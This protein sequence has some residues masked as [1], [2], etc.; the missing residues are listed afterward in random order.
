M[1]TEDIRQLIY[2]ATSRNNDIAR[3]AIHKLKTKDLLEGADGVL[4]G[5]DFGAQINNVGTEYD[6]ER[7]NF[8]ADLRNLDLRRVNLENARMWSVNFSFS[9]MRGSNL[10]GAQLNSSN[11]DGVIFDDA[12]FT[13]S[14][15]TMCHSR[16]RQQVQGSISPRNAS[17]EN[18]VFNN[19]NLTSCGLGGA[20]LKGANFIKANLKHT[21]FANSD[22][23]SSVF[24]HVTLGMTNFKGSNLTYAKFDSVSWRSRTYDGE[25][26]YTI[27]P[28]GTKW[29]ESTD[30]ARFTDPDH[31]QYWNP[32]PPHPVS[33]IDWL[34]HE[35]R[36]TVGDGWL[37]DANLSHAN[38][39][40]ANLKHANLRGADL[41]F[42][43]LEGADLTSAS[44]IG[45]NLTSARLIDTKLYNVSLIGAQLKGVVY[46]DINI[47]YNVV[48]PDGDKMYGQNFD[49][50]RFTDIDHPDYQKTTEATTLRYQK[51]KRD[52]E[53]YL[54][55]LSINK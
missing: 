24:S 54:K 19:T 5:V 50:K 16:G 27:L 45:V 51:W 53:E 20:N 35:D 9:D 10:S 33:F 49:M 12:N 4:R 13:N 48:L 29:N 7:I 46:S 34:R 52:T 44:L 37:Q 17:F 30:I 41:S 8:G 11:L 43:D 23:R 36:L 32:T 47:F 28:D 3:R 18:A 1:L 40:N 14:D 38:L 25:T 42:A 6:L 26:R 2:D 39:K 21:T 55:S 22:L 31:P 15:L